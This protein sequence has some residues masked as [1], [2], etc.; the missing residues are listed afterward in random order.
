MPNYEILDAKGNST[1]QMIVNSPSQ[2]E[3]LKVWNHFHD[4]PITLV[5]LEGI[6]VPSMFQNCIMSKD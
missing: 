2:E 3:A 1:G 5:P 4:E 6:N